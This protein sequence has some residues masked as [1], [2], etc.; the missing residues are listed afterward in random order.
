MQEK[1]TRRPHQSKAFWQSHIKQWSSSGQSKVDYCRTHDLNSASFYNWCSN[2]K[3][4]SIVGKKS[5]Q[6]TALKLLPVSVENR[7][8]LNATVS[9]HKAGLCFSFLANLPAEQI[10]RW[11]VGIGRLDV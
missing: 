5:A 7:V 8:D 11:L 10:E 6:K 4:A 9:L 2:E 1:V 3:A